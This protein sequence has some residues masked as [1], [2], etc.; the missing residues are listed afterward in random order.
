MYVCNGNTISYHM[1]NAIAIRWHFINTLHYSS[2]VEQV[3][4]CDITSPQKNSR[5]SQRSFVLTVL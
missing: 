4:G 5:C 2:D 3:F 1:E